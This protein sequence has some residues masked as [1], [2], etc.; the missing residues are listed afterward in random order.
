MLKDLKAAP[1]LLIFGGSRATRFEPSYLQELTGLRGFNLAFQ[2][3]R[4]EDAWAFT[5]YLRTLAPHAKP[6]VVWFVQVE[7]FREQ[8]LSPG[9]V[10]D[11]HL[12]RWFPAGLVK[13]ARATLPKTRAE[14]PKGRDLALTTYGPDGAVL[15]NRYDL[16]VKKGRTLKRAVDWS[17]SEALERYRT[18]TPALFPRTPRY[19]EVTV[20][21]L[22]D[23]G[24]Q[25]VVVFMPLHPRLLASVRPAGWTE[26]RTQVMGYLRGLQQKLTFT[27]LDFTSSPASGATRKGST[28]ASTSGRRTRGAW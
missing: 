7:A 17:I 12:S 23:M 5:N 24:T 1:Q 25:P 9:L 2:N 14:A 22:N 26:R 6:H 15:R 16:A 28:T 20:R 18:P 13:Q 19:F 8:G 4:P 27:V 3:G 11:P 21:L 10:Q